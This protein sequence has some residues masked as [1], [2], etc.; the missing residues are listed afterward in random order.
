MTRTLAR[1]AVLVTLACSGALAQLTG[2]VGPTTSTAAKQAT[3]CNVLNY[4]GAIGSSV[5]PHSSLSPCTPALSPRP[6][7]AQSVT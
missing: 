2:T 3:I 1:L 4:G 6:S 5:R 7:H